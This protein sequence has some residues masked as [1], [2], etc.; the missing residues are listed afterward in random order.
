MSMLA[1][2]VARDV[3]A[4]K[5]MRI[6]M[7]PLDEVN[8]AV[9][10]QRPQYVDSMVICVSDDAYQRASEV[11]NNDEQCEI[12]AAIPGV[13]WMVHPC[14]N[15]CPC[16]RQ[17]IS[18]QQNAPNYKQLM[19]FYYAGHKSHEGWYIA[20]KAVDSMQEF[21]QLTVFA[22][23][24][25]E[26][27]YVYS[28]VVSNSMLGRRAASVHAPYW[29]KKG[30]EGVRVMS[31]HDYQEERLT[32]MADLLQIAQNEAENSTKT[33][34]MH[35]TEKQYKQPNR[36]SWMERCA[37]LIVLLIQ[38]RFDEAKELAEQFRYMG[39]MKAVVQQKLGL[40]STNSWD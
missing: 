28:S 29:S 31:F 37:D 32:Q 19:M 25:G 16:F 24:R 17:E 39:T 35:T 27:G 1:R 34:Q 6:E 30:V 26:V 3:Q 15:G 12:L 33:Q 23:L 40:Y 21:R 8:A 11:D 20:D 13:Y 5:R 38:A 4:E 2:P 22:Y 7:L 36:A 9:G 18:T 10:C 14:I